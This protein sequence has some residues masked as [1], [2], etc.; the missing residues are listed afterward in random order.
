MD[1]ITTLPTEKT[2]EELWADY[3]EKSKIAQLSLLFEDGLEARR[4]WIQFMEIFNG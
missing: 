3:V 4:A 2:L 1:K